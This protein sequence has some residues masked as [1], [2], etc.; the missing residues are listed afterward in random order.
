MTLVL[1]TTYNRPRLLVQSL[2]QVAKEVLALD[3]SFVIADDQSDHEDTKHILGVAEARGGAHVIRRK[4]DR[5]PLMDQHMAQGA[6]FLFAME[7][8]VANYADGELGTQ[9]ILK[10]D[11]DLVLRPGAL[12]LMIRTWMRAEREGVDVLAV[13]GIRSTYH[14]LVEQRQ[15]YA[16]TRWVCNVACMYRYSDWKEIIQNADAETYKQI[17]QEG[18]DNWYLNHYRVEKRPDALG[19]TVTPSVVYH[20][21]KNSVHLGNQDINVDYVGDLTGVVIE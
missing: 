9:Y 15:G 20:T 5:Q 10:L 3:A 7:W 6:N 4:Y 1:M 16:I 14:P 8:L 18:W 11:D 2:P 21:C 13:S 12:E 17:L 19:V